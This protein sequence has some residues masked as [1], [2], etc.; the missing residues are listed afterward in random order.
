MTKVSFS[1]KHIDFFI[2]ISLWILVINLAY[3]IL[4]VLKFDFIYVQSETLKGFMSGYGHY[5]TN[6]GAPIGFM[7]STFC[8]ATF[9]AMMIPFLATRKGWFPLVCSGFLYIPLYYLHSSTN[10]IAA[11]ITSLFVIFY[12]FS[13]KVFISS[14]VILML[15]GGAYL[16]KVDNIGT[17]R[18]E[19]WSLVMEDAWI[20]PVVGWGLDSFRNYTPSKNFIY[21]MDAR[22]Y[23]DKKIYVNIWDNPH[24][25]LISLFYEFGIVGIFLFFGLLRQ[26]FMWF[27]KAP[28]D[29]NLIA[30][31]GA[32]LAVLVASMGHFP[33][34]LARTA[35]FIIPIA[36]LF[37]VEAR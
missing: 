35:V 34:F 27:R 21:T 23:M 29:P 14:L 10:L 37:E 4:Q 8:M 16:A 1:K 3:C 18:F 6:C 5:L 30:L 13:K 26:Y 22:K 19:Q 36:A 25:L 2:K 9:I 28:K 20:H 12:R 32:L 11:V 7:G 33:L 24:N 31:A 17:E 15:F